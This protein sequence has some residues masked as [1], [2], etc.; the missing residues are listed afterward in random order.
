MMRSP[1]EPVAPAR[2]RSGRTSARR[3]AL[4]SSM[5]VRPASGEAD[6]AFSMIEVALDGFAQMWKSGDVARLEHLTDSPDV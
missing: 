3:V 4:R 2:V 5:A 1:K 6:D